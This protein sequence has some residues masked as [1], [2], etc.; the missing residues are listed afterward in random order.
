MQ[1]N[2]SANSSIDREMNGGSE[3][4]HSQSGSAR[5][6]RVLSRARS[7]PSDY[8]GGHMQAFAVPMQPFI[9]VSTD[10]H[11]LSPSIHPE[12]MAQSHMR[13]YRNAQTSYGQWFDPWHNTSSFQVPARNEYL[14]PISNQPH[15]S[16]MTP[17]VVHHSIPVHEQSWNNFSGQQH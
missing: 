12:P 7:F 4:Y 17:E 5:R 3:H 11:S 2:V 14:P 6:I 13:T 16:T 10:A 1:F 8:D 9:P 15:Y